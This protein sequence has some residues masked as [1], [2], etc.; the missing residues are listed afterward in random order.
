MLELKDFDT[1][2]MYPGDT[3]VLR[4]REDISYEQMKSFMSALQKG[5]INMPF[6]ILL[7]PYGFELF[8]LKR[9]EGNA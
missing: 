2:R 6:K 4:P 9:E 7:V 8:R 3:L 1:I 5:A